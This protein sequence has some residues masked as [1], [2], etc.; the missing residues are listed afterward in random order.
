MQQRDPRYDVRVFVNLVFP[1]G[2]EIVSLLNLLWPN[3]LS[4]SDH[5]KEFVDVVPAV[6]AL[7]GIHPVST[8]THII[9]SLS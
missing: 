6:D 2:R 7:Y 1:S 4:D 3:A 5:P 8:E 9:F